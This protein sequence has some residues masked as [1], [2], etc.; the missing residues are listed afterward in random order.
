MNRSVQLHC[1]CGKAF[2][3]TQLFLGLIF[4]RNQVRTATGSEMAQ[5][6]NIVRCLKDSRV[7]QLALIVICFILRALR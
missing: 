6:S 3:Q 1:I 5:E 2:L 4:P 7:D